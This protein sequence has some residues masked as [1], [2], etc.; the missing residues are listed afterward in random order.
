MKI[1]DVEIAATSGSHGRETPIAKV[2]TL[3]LTLLLWT[4]TL[5]YSQSLT[6]V[7]IELGEDGQILARVV[8]NSPQDC[9]E[10]A[11]SGVSHPMS[12]RSPVPKGFKPACELTIPPSA[13]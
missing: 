4:A 3:K 7:W 11:I 1:E 5:L 12:L 2:A 13:T 6:P 10:V 9:P 8:V